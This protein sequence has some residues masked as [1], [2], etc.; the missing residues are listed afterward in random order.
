MIEKMAASRITTLLSTAIQFKKCNHVSVNKVETV[1]PDIG[2]DELKSIM[3]KNAEVFG[4]VDFNSTAQHQTLH[5]IELTGKGPYGNRRRLCPEK[6]RIAKQCFDSMIA[7]GICRPSCSEYAS[8]LHMVPKKDLTIG[9][10]VEIID[11]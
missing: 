7:T 5:R 3:I 2:N 10:L 9:G 1:I 4:D 8:P 11:E 6:Y